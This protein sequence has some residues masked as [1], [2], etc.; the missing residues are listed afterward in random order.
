VVEDVDGNLYLD[1]TSGF[2]VALLGHRPPAVVRAASAQAERLV[3]AMGDAF[4]DTQ[5]VLLLEALSALT[6]KG[7]DVALLG[8]SGSDA[9]DAAIKTAVLATKRTGVLTFSGGYHGLALGVLPMQSYNEAFGSPFEAITHPDVHNLPWGCSL[10][11][12][13]AV[14]AQYAIGLLLVEPILGRGGVHTAA[15]GWLETIS[16]CARR[17][18]AVVAFDEVKTGLG[19]TGDWW[20]GTR[21]GVSPDLLCVGKALGGGYPLSALVGTRDVMAS[22]GAS[23]GEAL[24]TQTFLGHPVA[25]AA[26]TASLAE[27]QRLDAPARCQERGLALREALASHGLPCRG[28]GLMLAVEVSS[29]ALAVCRAMLRRGVVALPAGATSIGLS[30]PMTITDPQI[31]ASVSALLGAIHEVS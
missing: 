26:A 22:W 24:H 29:P 18:G 8:Q 31:E 25:C 4:P 23:T 3:H 30:P 14:F 21:E 20:A 2:G 1:W 27:L 12:V 15:P 13:E 28:R 9:I 11:Q 10:E 17:H 5:R 7:L 6:P 16:A 19:R